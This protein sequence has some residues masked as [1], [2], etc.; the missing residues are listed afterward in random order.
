MKIIKPMRYVLCLYVAALLLIA[1]SAWTIASDKHETVPLQQGV[2]LAAKPQLNDPNFL[3]TVILLVSYGKEGAMGLVI[4]KPEYIQLRHLIPELKGMKGAS[5]P[6]YKGGPVNFND[7]HMLFSS[8]TPKEGDIRVFDHVHY[9]GRK[10][11]ILALL[12]DTPVKS[13]VMVYAGHAGW[14]PGQLELEIKRGDWI[15]IKADAAKIFAK[16][17]ARIWP[18]IFKIREDMMI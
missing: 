11:R 8:D 18:S 7:I 6:L 13:K 10:E 1:A 3:Q 15:T 2:F 16:D 14:A 4:N 5:I 12:Q 17:P 9:T